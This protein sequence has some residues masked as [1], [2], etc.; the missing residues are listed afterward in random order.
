MFKDFKMELTDNITRQVAVAT[1][2]LVA[3]YDVSVQRRFAVI[4]TDLHDIR[5]EMA[6]I[7]KQNE[8]MFKHIQDI[9][10]EVGVVSSTQTAQSAAAQASFHTFDSAKIRIS[11]QELVSIE[12]VMGVVAPWLCS[13]DLPSDS[14]ARLGGAGVSRN[15]AIRFK[16]T[17]ALAAKRVQ[18]VIRGLRQADGSWTELFVPTPSGGR[19]KLFIGAD[20]SP[21]TRKTIGLGKK[22]L[23]AAKCS[24]PKA[25]SD[26]LFHLLKNEGV[27]C[28]KWQHMVRVVAEA[29]GHRLEWNRNANKED[30]RQK[31]ITKRFADIVSSSR[32]QSTSWG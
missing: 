8:K 10:K 32:V 21:C 20:Q 5:E 29:D 28:Y 15:C 2:A 27:L 30:I 11:C 25:F 31:D 13:I 7:I 9:S 1:Q 14:F 12:A 17:E 16:G 24:A 4:D 22:L 6:A 3:K 19:A 26:G 18:Q 23:D